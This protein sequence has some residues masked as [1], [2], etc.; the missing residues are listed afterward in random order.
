MT[1]TERIT[2]TI[3]GLDRF[4]VIK[5]VADSG[6]KPWRAAERLGLTPQ[7]IPRLVGRLRERGPQSLVSQ[8]LAKIG[9]VQE[10]LLDKNHCAACRS[11][12][13]QQVIDAMSA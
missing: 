8:R 10:V 2:M 11:C 7:Q 4:K 13:R 6:L 9:D 12:E 5:E 1:A 3:R